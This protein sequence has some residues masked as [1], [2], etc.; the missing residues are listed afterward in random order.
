MLK[1][2]NIAIFCLLILL[3]YYFYLRENFVE[4]DNKKK[5]LDTQPI[6]L[7]DEEWDKKIE[8]CKKRSGTIDDIDLNETLLNYKPKVIL[9]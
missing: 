8:Y 5:F 6:N 3:I 2:L 4:K 7:D 1:I 9:Y